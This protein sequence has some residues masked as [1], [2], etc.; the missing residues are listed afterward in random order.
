MRRVLALR[1]LLAF[2]VPIALAAKPAASAELTP[3][4]REFTIGLQIRG[5]AWPATL[6]KDLV[7]GLTNR[8]L[9]HVALFADS[10]QLD[11]KT[12][13]IAIKYDLWEETFALTVTVSGAVILARNAETHPQ[14]DAFLANL[15]LPALFAASDVPK[16]KAAA[17]RV[18]M[19]L[20]PIERERLE[21][22]KK[23]VLE[24][25]TSIPADTSGF[26]DKRVG[27]SRANEVFNRIFE[28]YAQGAEAAATW[29]LSLSS[30]PFK[31]TEAG[32]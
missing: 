29:K 18:E 10:K 1:V 26:S 2:A 12:A 24:N 31:V 30:N 14:I 32:R 21:A 15:E 13:V 23:W 4:V 11:Q 27:N 3:V 5:I 9:I 19:L 6:P 22:I 16:D 20:N 17:L 8:V 28:Q 7:S 25:N